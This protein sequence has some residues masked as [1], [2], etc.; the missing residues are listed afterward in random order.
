MRSHH[1]INN[2]EHDVMSLVDIKQ[3]AWM[4]GDRNITESEHTF[5]GQKVYEIS[6]EEGLYTLDELKRRFLH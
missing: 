6:G 5:N 3:L 1:T 4:H 2:K